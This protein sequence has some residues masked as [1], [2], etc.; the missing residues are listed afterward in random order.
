MEEKEQRKNTCGRCSSRF[1]WDDGDKIAHHP[2]IT[3]DSVDYCTTCALV[4]RAA[5]DKIA[6]LKL[7]LKSNAKGAV[8]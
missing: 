7:R 3:I 8:S 6:L 2:R 4:V 1:T 5:K